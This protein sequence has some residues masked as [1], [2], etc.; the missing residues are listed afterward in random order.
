M[1]KLYDAQ[2]ARPSLFFIFFIMEE[3][4][5]VNHAFSLSASLAG[6]PVCAKRKRDDEDDAKAHALRMSL[7]SQERYWINDSEESEGDPTE[8][9]PYTEAQLW[10]SKEEDYFNYS[11]IFLFSF[12]FRWNF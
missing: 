1:Y 3:V 11:F 8:E 6:C 7:F 5:K 9:M 2:A 4:P 12:F 10:T